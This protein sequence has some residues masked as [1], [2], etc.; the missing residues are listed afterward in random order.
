MKKILIKIRTSLKFLILVSIATIFIMGLRSVDV[1]ADT[2]NY[3][4]KFNEISLTSW[5]KIFE[6][7]D[8]VLKYNGLEIGYV[9]TA[10][11]TSLIID[12][13]IF[14]QFL[15]ALIYGLS[16]VLFFRENVKSKILLTTVYLGSGLYLLPFNINR[17]MI[18]VAFTALSWNC[19]CK[20]KI[21]R[22][23]LFLICAVSFHYSTIF[24]IIAYIFY[25]I[26]NKKILFG[27]SIIGII[28]AFINYQFLISLVSRNFAIYG[29]YYGNSRTRQA[30]GLSIIIYS[31]LLLI[32]LYILISKNKFTS[33]EKVYAVFSMIY[34]ICNFIGVYFNYF[35]RIGIYFLPFII[36]ELDT[37]GKKIKAT[38]FHKL[39]ISGVSI[40]YSLYFLLS[41]TSEQYTY[42][43]FWDKIYYY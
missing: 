2:I 4:G 20:K 25:I 29:N 34:V 28:L 30:I 7:L 21:F 42:H 5:K 19:M 22:A 35:E 14:F 3:S 10:K 40:C 36:L 33:I 27:I 41:T 12:D 43:F 39:Y 16:M 1:G 23:F 31:I 26:R 15:L 38:D 6:S 17:Q 32:A 18:A 8:G 13:Y 37:I 24:F 11:V 9:I